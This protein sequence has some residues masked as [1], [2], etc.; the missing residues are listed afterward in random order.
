MNCV[1]SFI[2][3]TE[4]RMV[5]VRSTQAVN[6]KIH[7]RFPEKS[8]IFFSFFLRNIDGRLKNSYCTTEVSIVLDIHTPANRLITTPVSR[9]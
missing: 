3:F 4:L 9:V 5:P 7:F 6:K 8:R 1:S 2:P